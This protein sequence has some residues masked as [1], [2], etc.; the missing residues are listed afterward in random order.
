MLD[1]YDSDGDEEKKLESEEDSD[2][3]CLKVIHEGEIVHSLFS[4]FVIHLL[5]SLEL[6]ILV[7]FISV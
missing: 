7:T 2:Q 3:G 6:H 5:F 1:N 4:K